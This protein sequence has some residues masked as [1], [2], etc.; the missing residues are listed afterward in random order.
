MDDQDIQKLLIVTQTPPAYRKH[1]RTSNFTS[2]N[3]LTSDIAQAINDGLYFYEQVRCR[4][5][6]AAVLH[7]HTIFVMMQDLKLELEGSDSSYT[8]RKVRYT[9]VDED[10]LH[11]NIHDACLN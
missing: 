4:Q 10:F 1:D 2:K 5:M 7:S 6:I 8:A 9:L 3:K 11:T